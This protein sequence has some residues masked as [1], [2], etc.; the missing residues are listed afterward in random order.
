MWKSWRRRVAC[1]HCPRERRLTLQKL[2][3]RQ[4]C[5]W[6]AHKQARSRL[7]WIEGMHS[8]CVLESSCLPD[9]QWEA[10]RQLWV[11]NSPSFSVEFEAQ[12]KRFIAYSHFLLFL[13]LVRHSTGKSFSQRRWPRLTVLMAMQLKFE[14]AVT[15]LYCT[16]RIVDFLPCRASNLMRRWNMDPVAC[17]WGFASNW[18]FSRLDSTQ[19]E[20]LGGLVLSFPP[21]L[22]LCLL[23]DVFFSYFSSSFVSSRTFAI[24]CI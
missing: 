20:T 11:A 14:K 22:F 23:L 8:C 13:L 12:L 18:P 9:C 6:S 2:P 4:P 19:S 17:R 16:T 24:F 1:F 5:L 3:R 7:Q 21:L 15:V 10:T